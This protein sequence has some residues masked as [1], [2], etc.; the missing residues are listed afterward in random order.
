MKQSAKLALGIV[1]IAALGF[2]SLA[3]AADGEDQN[4]IP[5]PERQ[6]Q[7]QEIREAMKSGDK[8][9]VE[10]L[11]EL[12]DFKGFEGHGMYKK[13]NRGQRGDWG[14]KGEMGQEGEMGKNGKHFG[15]KGMW[16]KH[17]DPENREAVK[18]AIEN[19]DYAAFLEVAGEKAEEK[20]TE[21]KFAEM[22]AGHQSKE[23]AR[24]AMESGDYAAF[25]SALGDKALEDLTEE[26]FNQMQEVRI[27]KEAGDMEKVKELMEEY[28]IKGMKKPGKGCRKGFGD[29]E[30]QKWLGG[31]E[32][33]EHSEGMPNNE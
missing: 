33:A 4:F 1:A 12:Y 16:K 32:G 6:A 23:A 15:K 27:A 2:S 24:I 17:I 22:V 11:K 20:I 21:E 28:G 8:E 29:H 25:I 19:N 9:K 18:A 7:I 26:K 5:D 3:S 10:E 30:G 14:R 13:G 31:P